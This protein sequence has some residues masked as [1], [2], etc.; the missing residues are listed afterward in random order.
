MK[1]K[2]VSMLLAAAM[3]ASAVSTGAMAEKSSMIFA[4][5]NECETLDPGLCNYLDSST[6]L[7]NLFMGL[8]R[9]DSTGM[10]MTN[11]CAESYEVSE[12]GKTYTFYLYDDLLWSDGT[13]LTAAD[14]EY[15]WKRMLNPETASAAVRDMFLLKNGEL[16]NAGKCEADEVGVKAV[17]ATTLVVEL[18]NPASYFI[19]MTAAA[20]F[21]PVQKA[22]VEASNTWSQKADTFVCNGAFRIAEINP[23]ESYVLVKN[24]TYKYAD[25][26]SLD[27]VK[28]VFIED[29]TATLTALKNGEIDMTNNISTQAQAEFGES[30][31]LLNFNSLGI[32]YFDFNCTTLTDARVRK[33][34]SLAI[35]RDTIN[36]NFIPNRPLS[37]EGF[38]PAGLSY[39]ES[40][41]DFRTVAGS[42]VSYD[43]ET[44]KALLDEA[45]ADGFD[46]SATYNIIIQNKE[47]LK[48]TAQAFQAM[49]KENLGLNF[50]I[51]TYESGSYWDVFYDGDFDVAYDGWT[52]DSDD[53][54]AMLECFTQTACMTQNRWAGEKAEAYDQ[55]M[56]DCAA[57]LDQTERFKKYVEAEKL[58]IEESPIMPLYYKKSQILVGDGVLYATNDNMG[59]TLFQYTVMN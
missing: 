6:M 50:E 39:Y 4:V 45:V 37:A 3:A 20:S 32:I 51:T 15:S 11:G 8:Y 52:A 33:A 7:L 36:Q 59:H 47:E 16:Y 40:E 18:E 30:E 54:S 27:E 35:D 21:A 38:V 43:V 42:L 12:D 48:T 57:M 23:E 19:D 1:K 29:G 24:E 46:A 28:V 58:L 56:K 34:L 22:A 17:D 9:K 49:W 41:D 5:A 53:P 14:F 31:Q 25:T 26:I 2:L 10:V 55:M 13:P 44:A